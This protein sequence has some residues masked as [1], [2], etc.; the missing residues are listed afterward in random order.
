[1]LFSNSLEPLSTLRRSLIPFNLKMTIF[2]FPM[3]VYENK[4]KF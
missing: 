3:E 1:M 2:G 4:E